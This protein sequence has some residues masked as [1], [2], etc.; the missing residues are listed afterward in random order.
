MQIIL[1]IVFGTIN[2]LIANK[3]GFNPVLWFFA[4]GF[5]GLIVI[6][7]MPSA[8]AVK[9]TQPELYLKRKKAGNTAGAIILGI[10]VLATIALIGRLN[11][12]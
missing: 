2:A 5:L 7:I 4:A 1:L 3:K 6:L 10:V 9:E 8:S 11:S 12:L